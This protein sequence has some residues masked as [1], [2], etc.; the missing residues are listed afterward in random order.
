LKGN[1][2]PNFPNC[3]EK[4]TIEIVEEKTNTKIIINEEDETNKE[5]NT[6]N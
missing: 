3:E 5:E 1:C 6:E 2:G 4:K